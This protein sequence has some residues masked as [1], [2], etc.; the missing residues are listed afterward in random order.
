MYEGNTPV[1]AIYE[2]SYPETVVRQGY[3]TGPKFSIVRLSSD[4]ATIT[5]TAKYGGFTA[6]KDFKVSKSKGT[7][8]YQLSTSANL[9][10]Y[11]TNGIPTPSE[12]EISVSK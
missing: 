1:D 2:W 7:T 9:F 4:Y 8:V 10:N 11:D 6:S 3:E 12:I 5:C